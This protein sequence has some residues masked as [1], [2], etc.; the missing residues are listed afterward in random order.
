MDTGLRVV[1]KKIF[2][3]AF[4]KQIV[5]GEESDLRQVLA[6]L[7]VDFLG[8]VGENINANDVQ[9]F[10]Q[11]FN[12]TWMT[13]ERIWNVWALDKNR[14]NNHMEGWHCHLKDTIQSNPNPWLFIQ[15]IKAEQTAKEAE[16]NLMNNEEVIVPLTKKMKKTER[17]LAR[18]KD[19]C[20]AG[21]ITPLQYVARIS[22]LMN[23]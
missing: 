18:Y 23:Y 2:A 11:Y 17:K 15:K 20:N 8:L 10:L 1:I 16:V 4:L 19:R 7:S 14:T 21:H 6:I 13:R 5:N 12:N 3:L 22:V 9:G